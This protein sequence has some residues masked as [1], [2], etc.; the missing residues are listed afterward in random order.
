MLWTPGVLP[1]GL[2]V[3]HAAI[4]G[5]PGPCNEYLRSSN[6]LVELALTVRTNGA[7]QAT[8]FPDLEN[9]TGTLRRLLLLVG[10]AGAPN[11]TPLSVENIQQLMEM[12]FLE[13]LAI[14]LQ[15]PETSPADAICACTPASFPSL[16]YFWAFAVPP[17]LARMVHYSFDFLDEG[18]G[19]LVQE[20]RHVRDSLFRFF[21]P[22]FSTRPWM[23]ISFGMAIHNMRAGPAEQFVVDGGNDEP[24]RIKK[25]E[26]LDILRRP[27]EDEDDD[28]D[29]NVDGGERVDWQS[30][31]SM[32]EVIS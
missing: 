20:R 2:S 15:D 25:T 8:D 4:E 13:Q 16:R 21:Y 14:T 3:L 24:R 1:P 11:H 5:D 32:A 22:C 6:S 19:Q 26:K 10:D 30:L 12:P 23:G 31:I 29:A 17:V 7:E 9:H 28:N 18:D 27:E